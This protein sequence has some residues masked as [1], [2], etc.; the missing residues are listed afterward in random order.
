MMVTL[1]N[2]QLNTNVPNDAFALELPAGAKIV[3]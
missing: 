2:L 3:K 1:K